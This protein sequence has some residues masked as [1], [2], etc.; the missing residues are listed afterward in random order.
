MNK[1]EWN[2]EEVKRFWDY[3]SQ[4]KENYFTYQVGDILAEKFKSYIQNK[5]VLDY[6]AGAG[7]FCEQLA[8]SGASTFTAV[9]YS[10]ESIKLLNEKFG[11]ELSTG[12]FR[13]AY[14]VGELLDKDKQFDTIF[15]FEVIEHLTDDMLIEVFDN[16]KRLLKKDGS[17][18]I[19]TPNEENLEKSYICCP[20]CGKIFHRWQHVRSW[21]VNSLLDY[22]D[23]RGYVSKEIG[24]YNL[25]EPEVSIKF[26]IRHPLLYRKRK[27]N[28]GKIGANLI[29]IVK[30][31][32]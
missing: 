3:E 31:K 16:I 30:K 18:I 22:L 21:S 19:T 2:Q 4:F 23:K 10:S 11:E 12:K 26:K 1:N 20:C 8:Q 25:G 32:G 13:G 9:E 28:E 27:A 15:L 14:T 5:D 29:A 7:F 17:L 6:G 24:C